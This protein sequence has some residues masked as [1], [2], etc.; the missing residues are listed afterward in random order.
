MCACVYAYLSVLVRNCLYFRY[1]CGSCACLVCTH[2]S[3]HVSVCIL[4][5]C[6]FVVV[7]ERENEG[8]SF[9]HLF[10]RPVAAVSLTNTGLTHKHVANKHTLNKTQTINTLDD[11]DDEMMPV[12]QQEEQSLLANDT[13]G[14]RNS[15]S[16]PALDRVSE[17]VVY[18]V[19]CLVMHSH[20]L[21]IVHVY[22]QE[23]Q[24]Q[25]AEIKYGVNA[26]L[27]LIKPVSVTMLIVIV[28]I[29]SVSYYQQGASDTQQQLA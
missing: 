11:D 12:G 14:R 29:R 18:R 3:V 27:S 16:R 7:E 19:Y 28:T 1:S 23:Q 21:E 20:S 13:L 6:V 9:V 25:I 22:H 15:R 4:A 2:I 10:F 24:E 17:I 5:A 26:V 8:M